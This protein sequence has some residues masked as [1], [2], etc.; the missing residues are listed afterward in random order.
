MAR[1]LLKHLPTARS[2]AR[3]SAPS[4]GDVVPATPRRRA[5]R[6]AADTDGNQAELLAAAHQAADVHRFAGLGPDWFW[7][8]A[9]Q[10]PQKTCWS[11]EQATAVAAKKAETGWSLAKLAKY[12]KK[13]I[14][15]VRRALKNIER[16]A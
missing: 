1:R 13:G 12:F 3:C 5:I 8:D 9:F 15:T 7:E 10:V 11:E 4:D 14:P 6:R 2:A 16:L